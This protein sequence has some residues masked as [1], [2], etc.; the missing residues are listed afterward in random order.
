MRRAA[1]VDTAHPECVKYLVAAG[2]SVISLAAVGKGCP[3]L[4]VARNGRAMLMEVKSPKR[5]KAH[6]DVLARQALWR[7]RWRGPE[8]PTVRSGVEALEA[9][10]AGLK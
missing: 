8:V 6:P 3:D 9:A 7:A 1:K 5:E 2:Y 10:M 4:L